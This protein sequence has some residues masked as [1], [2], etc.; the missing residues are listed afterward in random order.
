MNGS[1]INRRDFLK[2]CCATAAMGAAGPT[3]MFSTNA[4]AAGS[5]ADTIVH[6]FLRGG[7]DGLNFVMPV[8]GN[9]RMEYE[10]LRPNI[11][12]PVSG[13]GA[14]LPLAL[15][16]GMASGFGLHPSANGLRDLW[17]DGKMAIVQSCGLLTAVTRSHFDAQLYLDLGTPGR[18]GTPTGWLTR[19]WESQP[20]ATGLE[21]MPELAMSSRIPTNL[22]GSTAALAMNS[23]GDLQLN[24]GPYQWQKNRGGSQPAN[25]R[26]V[27]ET[28]QK[29]WQ[30]ATGAER[31][32]GYAERSLRIV[33]S[34]PYTT[35]LP[36][37]WPNN[38]FSR[39][40]WII[41]QSI[42]F[43]IGLRYA[44][45]DVGGWDTHENQGN[46][47]GGYYA[48]RIADLS[49]SLA[50]FYAEL[51]SGGEAG[52]VTVMVQSEFG[53]RAKQNGSGGTDHGYGNPMIVL[54]G[55]VNGRKLYGR[56]DGLS[57]GALA[58]YFGDVPVHTDY[59]QVFSELMIRRMGNNQLGTVFPGYSNYAPLGIVQGQ[60]LAPNY[61]D[62]SAAVTAGRRQLPINPQPVY[63]SSLQ[64]HPAEE[65]SQT[66]A[67]ERLKGRGERLMIRRGH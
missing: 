15:A 51:A 26:G 9:D 36:S 66:I 44:T 48:G 30:G 65:T 41:A 31:V 21:L 1:R 52:R 61:L 11:K 6:V 57:A 14:A 17:V 23:P 34:Q 50:A 47:G 39:Q 40:L 3:L 29:L 55:Q 4:N 35:A 19:A 32:G 8:S 28:M 43:N 67:P 53:R 60:D 33:A 27:N 18:V 2:G 7:F 37:D 22:Q 16:G 58:P 13:A 12:V 45:L 5:P 56:W 63:G 54:G 20:D 24:S 64:A 59:R 38:S 49:S 25:F 62:L 10:A 42:R 46:D